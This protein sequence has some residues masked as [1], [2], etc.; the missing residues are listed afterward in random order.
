ML[1]SSTSSA[2]DSHVSEA[3][4]RAVERLSAS[5]RQD[6]ALRACLLVLVGSTLLAG[7][8]VVAVADAAVTV[9]AT[10]VKVTA[11]AVGA[12]ADAVI[13]DGDDDEED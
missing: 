1:I 4:G 9:V 13:P 2:G 5:L 6:H 8:A 7:C 3:Q 12:A 11:K 10:G